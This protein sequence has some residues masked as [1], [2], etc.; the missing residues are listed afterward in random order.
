[1]HHA[2]SLRWFWSLA[3]LRLVCPRRHRGRR[4]WPSREWS[5]P[6]ERPADA[7]LEGRLRLAWP[8][9]RHA[10]LPGQGR[11]RTARPYPDLAGSSD[12]RS[13]AAGLHHPCASSP[14][15]VLDVLRPSPAHPAVQ[16]EQ[17][18]LIEL[19]QGLPLGLTHEPT[20]SLCHRVED[21]LVHGTPFHRDWRDSAQHLPTSLGLETFVASRWRGAEQNPSCQGLATD[22]PRT[23]TAHRGKA[24]GCR[25]GHE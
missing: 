4:H 3:V 19:D 23:S 20:L 5:W 10:G 8:S 12:R 25:R 14:P 6:R 24:S 16:L 21:G 1:M 18:V 7:R 9:P 2:S 15:I 11:A 13:A 22:R 17:C